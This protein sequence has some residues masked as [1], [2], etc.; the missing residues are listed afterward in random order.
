MSRN[1]LIISGL[2]ISVAINLVLIGGIGYRASSIRDFSPRPFPPNVGWVVRDLSEERRSELEPMLRESYDEIRPMRGE[3]FAAQSRINELM[4]S[5][6]FDAEALNQAFAELR[7]V[8]ER[9]QALSHQQTISILNEL[10]EEE[11]QMAMEFVQRRGPREGRG[12]FR[13]QDGGPRFGP[14]GR[15][16]RPPFSPPS[17]TDDPDQ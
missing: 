2:V 4:A 5:Q 12:R 14:N 13:G 6:S 16:G 9:Y 15:P 11:R 1:R 7:D 3:M 8:S 10:S 17:P